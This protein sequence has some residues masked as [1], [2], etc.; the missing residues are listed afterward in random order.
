ME[1]ELLELRKDIFLT[2]F[3]GG[4]AHLASC[5]SSLEILY[6]L[7]MEGILKLRRENPHWH[8]RDRFILSKGHA[9]LAL[10]AV[11]WR[12]GLIEEAMYRSYLQENAQIGGEPCT[13]DCVWVEA[14]T[15]SLGHGL[16]MGIA[17][18]GSSP[19]FSSGKMMK[20]TDA[21]PTGS[22]ESLSSMTLST[23]LWNSI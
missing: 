13:R 18:C 5:F 11:L 1:Q 21:S 7:Y 10:Y 2:G 3:K 9:G 22:E 14:T 17:Q 15:G 12:V 20:K 4:M 19:Q 23:C 6:A 16:S 8:D